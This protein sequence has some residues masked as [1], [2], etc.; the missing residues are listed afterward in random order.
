MDL[1][2]GRKDVVRGSSVADLG[3]LM[4]DGGR[5]RDEI[6]SRS[7]GGGEDEINGDGDWDDDDDE[8]VDL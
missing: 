7:G 5:R 1:Q 6:R 3:R 4:S 8:T 2:L